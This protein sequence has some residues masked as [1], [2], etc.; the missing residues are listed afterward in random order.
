MTPFA[1]AFEDAKAHA[2][3]MYPRESCGLIVAGKYI[4][5]D[6]AADPVEKHIEGDPDCTCQLCSFEIN[7]KVY[8]KYAT[9]GIDMVVHSHPNGPFHPSRADML[10]QEQTGK[11]WAIIALDQDRISDPIIWGGDTPMAPVLGREFMH[12]IHD[13]YALIQDCFALGK[14]KLEAQ[15]VP[16]WPYEPI[17][18]MSMPRDNSWWDKGQD[19]YMENFAKAGFVEIDI[20]KAQPG[21]VFLTSIRSDKLN[22]GGVLVGE[23]CILHH[24]PQRLSRREPAGLWGRQA[25]FWLHYVGQS[26]A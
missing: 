4:A 3:E 11:A 24:L 15:G 10:S 17:K 20:S 5:C 7:A 2:R 6:N 18:L 14:E 22:H 12:G 25:G 9:K 16:G 26:N 19:L 8:A 13:C 1:L 21:D 23:S